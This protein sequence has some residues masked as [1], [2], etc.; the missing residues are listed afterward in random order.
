M[1]KFVLM[2]QLILEKN[3]VL[4][5][6]N[7]NTFFVFKHDNDVLKNSNTIVNK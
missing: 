1:Y 5:L 6:S 4:V 2:W 3:Y 7:E